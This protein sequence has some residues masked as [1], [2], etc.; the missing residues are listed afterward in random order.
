M[1]A[2][3]PSLWFWARTLGLQGS[4]PNIRCRMQ[5]LQKCVLLVP[6]THTPVS[7]R[8]KA[9]LMHQNTKNDQ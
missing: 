3:L 9:V 6:V 1:T 2:S 5:R 4:G 7:H 8:V